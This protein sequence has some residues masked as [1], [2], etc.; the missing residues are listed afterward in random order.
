MN[1]KELIEKLEQF[2]YE[3]IQMATYGSNDITKYKE[4][5]SELLENRCIQ[6]NLP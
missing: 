2:R 5:R 1:K 3:L 6:D 4:L